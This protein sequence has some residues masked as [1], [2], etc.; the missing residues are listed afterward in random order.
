MACAGRNV[1]SG[2]AQPGF[3]AGV[4]VVSLVVAGCSA[5]PEI[6]LV[7]EQPPRDSTSLAAER[8]PVP[9]S[10]DPAI[11]VPADPWTT[12]ADATTSDDLPVPPLP[13]ATQERRTHVL[14]PGDTLYGLAR[15]YYGD[16]GRW[17]A[18]LEANRDRIS[19]PDRILVGQELVI[20]Q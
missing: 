15:R 12:A 13:D 18:I 11:S 9:S 8:A 20:P 17:R 3:A 7:P 5:T 14:A 1:G 4:L 19:D 16:S 2:L 10:P 6:P